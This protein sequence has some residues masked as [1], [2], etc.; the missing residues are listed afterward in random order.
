MKVGG[1]VPLQKLARLKLELSEAVKKE[2]YER[3]AKLR[4]RILDLK[5][6]LTASPKRPKYKSHVA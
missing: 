6:Q 3:A 4:D 5:E 1:T 2:E